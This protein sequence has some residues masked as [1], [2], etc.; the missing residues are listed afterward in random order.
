[1][2]GSPQA[3]LSCASRLRRLRVTALLYPGRSLLNRGLARQV[4][5]GEP[6]PPGANAKGR[7]PPARKNNYLL[8]PDA[9]IKVLS[10]E[11]VC[12][13]GFRVFPPG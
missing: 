12:V 5:A 7:C 11:R 10:A 9:D 1:M 13:V 2:A 4:T 8:R 6:Q 3:H